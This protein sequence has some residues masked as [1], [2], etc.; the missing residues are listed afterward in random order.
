MRHSESYDYSL[1]NDI[2]KF[3]CVLTQEQ[4]TGLYE[5]DGVTEKEKGVLLSEKN[6]VFASNGS[7][8]RVSRKFPR[9]ETRNEIVIGT[10]G[11]A[12]YL[13]KKYYYIC[14]KTID[15]DDLNQIAAE[16]L[17]SAAHY[18]I[19]SNLAKFSTYATKCIENSLKSAIWSPKRKRVKSINRGDFFRK[20]LDKCSKL[21]M[22]LT[23]RELGNERQ[24]LSTILI[25][26]NKLILEHNREMF[27][28]K[29]LNRV[30]NKVSKQ[31][32]LNDP[33]IKLDE[34]YQEFIQIINN[35]YFNLFIGQEE[36]EV[37]DLWVKYIGYSGKSQGFN[38]YKN[39]NPMEF[40]DRRYSLHCL[41]YYIDWYVSKLSFMEKYLNTENRLKAENN[42]ILPTEEEILAAMNQEIK[43]QNKIKCQLRKSSY[44]GKGALS[45]PAFK[46]YFSFWEEYKSVYG[47]D[48]LKPGAR[49]QEIHEIANDDYYEYLDSLEDCM[50]STEEKTQTPTPISE[51]D[52]VIIELEK[53]KKHVHEI[54]KEKNEP[55]ERRNQEI[56]ILRDIAKSG[57]KL[58]KHYTPKDIANVND[59][60]TKLSNQN[61]ELFLLIYSGRNI[62]KLPPVRTIADE[63]ITN[64]FLEKYHDTLDNLPEMERKVM[65]LYYDEY[66]CHSMTASNIGKQLNICE[67]QVYKL[68]RSAIQRLQKDPTMISFYKEFL[69]QT[70]NLEIKAEMPSI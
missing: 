45:L 28:R 62:A 16:A 1:S 18:Y 8:K 60:L 48:L 34:L 19:P 40:F 41:Y 67:T 39:N 9:N 14:D 43:Q 11:L 51:E 52:F 63:A 58:I 42:G 44:H 65:G 35:G 10:F 2:L 64:I 61:D 13:A 27:Y 33:E 68:K 69:S 22:Y 53:R 56:A 46:E 54:L 59:D 70:S 37:V 7:S 50:D 55:R 4:I 21:K 30:V 17:I 32:Y 66:G 15:L 47:I 3:T 24:S 20:E 38:S 36:K 23:A 31:K 5:A 25:K 6:L 29:E 12:I 26:M 57:R 49:D